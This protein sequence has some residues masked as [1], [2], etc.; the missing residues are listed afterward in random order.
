MLVLTNLCNGAYCYSVLDLVV[1]STEEETD[2]FVELRRQ[3]VSDQQALAARVTEEDTSVWTLEG[4]LPRYVSSSLRIMPR[5]LLLVGAL[6][7]TSGEV[8][9]PIWGSPTQSK[10]Q[11]KCY[12]G[13][14]EKVNG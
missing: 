9:H 5:S 10:R 2:A 12:L 3:W 7:R 4:T 11:S 13:A 6:P 1:T 8:A 14:F